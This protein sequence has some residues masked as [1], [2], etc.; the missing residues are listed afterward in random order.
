M[1]PVNRK[2]ATA[3]KLVQ[4]A[5][6]QNETIRLGGSTLI[7][8][9][10]TVGK[11]MI[12][13]A[14]TYCLT[15][16]TQFN[17]AAQDR[18]RTVRGYVRG[19]TSS[20]GKDRFLRSGMV[21]SYIAVEFFAPDENVY[22]VAGVG[23]ESADETHAE[24]K[25]FLLKDT[26]LSDLNFCRVEDGKLKVT[27]LRI[28]R[29]GDRALKG[30]DFMPR[31]TG[32]RQ[33]LQALGLRMANPAKY[34]EKLTRMIAFNPE[35]NIDRFIQESVLEESD[36][37]SLSNLREQ[38][39]LFDQLRE[40]YEML[41][42]S[43]K[44]LETVQQTITEYEQKQR[45]LNLDEML[46]VWQQVQKLREEKAETEIRLAQY[47]SRLRALKAEQEKAD[48]EWNEAAAN[49]QRV[50]QDPELSQLT[51]SLDE[52][53]KQLTACREEKEK[54]E[55][56]TA[57]LMHLQ[58]RFQTSLRFLLEGAV[59]DPETRRLLETIGEAGDSGMEKRN[60]F[61]LISAQAVKIREDLTEEKVL[62][63][64]EIREED[65]RISAMEGQIKRLEAGKPLLPPEVEQARD[66][67]RE[68]LARTGK[69]ADIRAF[70]ELVEDFHDEA[71]RGAVEGFLGERRFHLLV[72]ASC[73]R[74]AV[75]IL[76]RKQIRDAAVVMA[77][78][79][80]DTE[81]AEGSAAGLL[82]I[83]NPDARR[84]ANFL[85]NGIRLCETPE[86]VQEHPQG[87]LTRQ[88]LTAW[89][90][91]VRQMDPESVDPALGPGA[92][93]L[94]KARLTE[95]KRAL[96]AS[97]NGHYARRDEVEKKLKA[98]EES[99]W[100]EDHYVFEAPE[101][102]RRMERQMNRLQEQLERLRS[103]PGLMAAI[104]VLEAARK[105]AQD[106][107]EARDR[108]I[109]DLRETENEKVAE[110]RQQ[111]TL[112]AE[113]F[114]AEEEWEQQRLKHLE[115]VEEMEAAY[116]EARKKS[117]GPLVLREKTVV[118]LRG[119]LAETVRR[120]EDAQ[121]E[122]LKSSEQDL[123]R[124]GVAFISEF[125]QEYAEISNV[126]IEKAK[127]ELDRKALELEDALLSDFVA[128]INEK[129][130]A[131]RAELKA[132]NRE[133]ESLPFGRDTYRFV[134]IERPDRQ[135]FFR[136]S[137]RLLEYMNM[138]G[139]YRSLEG[140]Q[141]ERQHDIHTLLQ[142]I[143]EEEDDREYMDY[144]KY[145][146]YDMQILSRQGEEETLADLSRKQGSAS[147]G[148]KQTP[149]YLILSAALM[150]YY[151]R[152]RCCVRLA[153]IDEAFAA[154]SDERVS[155]MVQY[156][157]NNHFQVI[158]AAPP[159]K[160]DTISRHIT[161]TVSLVACGRYTRAIEGAIKDP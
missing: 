24:A 17:K 84:Y 78:R 132:I 100:R 99:D 119:E 32:V 28:L 102:I 117:G 1:N 123:N 8:G 136:V 59:E 94:Q 86:E 96:E 51:G 36:A 122:Y 95:R 114:L 129:I 37:R 58:T 143:L 116:R 23:I 128:E 27:P 25:W 35:N 137:H 152:D 91:S 131:A 54:Y 120:L 115:L 161:T 53:E 97:R 112:A 160:L 45:R 157:E 121:L 92:F 159:K 147:G 151:P 34:R 83:P 144:R 77:D 2:T 141:D 9:P 107:W 106:A 142:A 33:I 80:P 105:R 79:L 73:R 67:L 118:N 111:A 66:L 130:S 30:S 104:E 76:S 62:L 6:Y 15:G 5:R 44:C 140:D 101:G 31:D 61:V 41:L 150:Q 82:S 52:L 90:Y 63:S 134:M 93:E 14:M 124:R 98:L 7:T 16:N 29:A 88:G 20:V 108:L 18:D 75:N 72:E 50:E 38:K 69:N 60:A 74:E 56:E 55:T 81:A 39:H 42:H 103:D 40:T 43:R 49:R 21:T 48:R 158:Y 13:D 127:A 46:L 70:S 85:L 19:D 156:F 126:K 89:A 64:R 71:W 22:L 57:R 65:A 135:A 12:L 113:I 139:V 155:Q 3:I 109:G 148:E 110:E 125:R 146:T 68:E 87:G 26:R 154:M 47:E 10:N 11:T 138:P 145:F 149:Y 4:W 153:F 133:L